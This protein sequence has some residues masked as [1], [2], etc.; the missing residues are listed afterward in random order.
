MENVA[1]AYSA[2]QACARGSPLDSRRE[3]VVE[4]FV[5][6]PIGGS[7]PSLS[8][9]SSA[10]DPRSFRRDLLAVGLAAGDDSVS[11]RAARLSSAQS[12]S[13]ALRPAL[14]PAGSVRG[15]ERP[16]VARA[17]AR[18]PTSRPFARRPAGSASAASSALGPFQVISRQPACHTEP[19]TAPCDHR[20]TAS[21]FPPAP[22][23]AAARGFRTTSLAFRPPPGANTRRRRPACEGL[24]AS[25][26]HR[27]RLSTFPTYAWAKRILVSP[28]KAETWHP[29]YASADLSICAGLP[30][31]A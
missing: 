21:S 5:H 30:H 31:A 11:A 15:P 28:R 7:L 23:L 12:R 3:S 26:D 29:G 19:R 4:W 9:G 22:P 16:L 24:V 17:E 14:L 10:I 6:L 27:E 2:L 18:S 8:V 20:S 1:W 13:S 25:A